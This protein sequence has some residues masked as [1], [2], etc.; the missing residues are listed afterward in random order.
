[1]PC[2]NKPIQV[3]V[4]ST[5]GYK[6]SNLSVYRVEAVQCI[7]SYS[8]LSLCV[9]MFVYVYMGEHLLLELVV[10]IMSIFSTTRCA[11]QTFFSPKS[12]KISRACNNRKYSNKTLESCCFMQDIKMYEFLILPLEPN[13]IPN[14]FGYQK[15]CI[16][17]FL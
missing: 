11:L 14:V 16:F 10:F 9:V 2:E 12:R 1:M 8:S 5:S 4:V 13:F 17:H 3:I 15:I 6:P 7:Y